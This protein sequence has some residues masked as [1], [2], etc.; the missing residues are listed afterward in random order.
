MGASGFENAGKGHSFN[1][2]NNVT[3]NTNEIRL[4]RIAA[5]DVSTNTNS[6]SSSTS[7]LGNACPSQGENSDTST[8]VSQEKSI[9]SL[10]TSFHDLMWDNTTTTSADQERWFHQGIHTKALQ[11]DSD[12]CKTF[13]TTTTATGNERSVDVPGLEKSHRGWGLTQSH[14]GP[15]G[16][17]AAIQAEMIRAL[18]NQQQQNHVDITLKEI[19]EALAESMAC[20]LAR[21]ALAP[22][23]GSDDFNSGVT[24]HVVLV[25]PSEK[26]R[27]EDE[28]RLSWD[29][30]M[31]KKGGR[32]GEDVLQCV[33]VGV[34]EEK[35]GEGIGKEK[36]SNE[37][38]VKKLTRA[39]SRY[40][41][42]SVIVD[43]AAT[44]MTASTDAV[45][46]SR[47][48]RRVLEYFYGQGGVLLFTMSLVA[49]RGV[50]RIHNDMDNPTSSHLTT[51][52][53][54]SG[55][56]MINLLLTGQA[57]SNVF[58]NTLT[59][60]GDS[61]KSDG[62]Q[63]D[64]IINNDTNASSSNNNV[65]C[66]GI[67]SQPSIGYLSQLESL[68]YC[69]V[70]GYYKSPKYPIW[71]IGSTSH[72]SVLFGED[73][74]LKESESDVL[75]ERCRRAFKS[76]EG[77]EE[78]GFIGVDAL[79]LVLE[80]LDLSLNSGN[81]VETLAASLEVSGA[82]II[83]WDDFWKAASRLLT[84]ASFESVLRAEHPINGSDNQT[85]LEDIIKNNVSSSI[86]QF[87]EKIVAIS[88][89]TPTEQ[90]LQSEEKEAQFGHGHT[91]LEQQQSDASYITSPSP[92]ENDEELAQRLA[93]EWGAENVQVW[94]NGER[95]GGANAAARKSD[96]ELARELQ[97]QW[98]AIDSESNGGGGGNTHVDTINNMTNS[99]HE[100]DDMEL[101]AINEQTT[102][103]SSCAEKIG[104]GR[105]NPQV[106]IGVS[107]NSN[108][109]T[110]L[111]SIV[112]QEEV[113]S[114]KQA[115]FDFEKFG[116]SFQLHHYNG[117]RGGLLTS[118]HVTRLSSQEAV[119]A[120]VA[121]SSTNAQSALTLSAGHTGSGGA[122]LEDIVRTKYP[123]CTFNWGG[124][125]P[126]FID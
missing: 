36:D 32:L 17:L 125:S 106:P 13:S 2:V 90:V 93:T 63:N 86:T 91:A 60:G 35:K 65:K 111:D 6:I 19:R 58:D 97:A 116:E 68:R 108:T 27:E 77:G 9:Q 85:D 42:A 73:D 94:S 118:F 95:K 14:G 34:N 44:T 115:S 121:L 84:G 62:K 11:L 112:V 21:A 74:C 38:R 16:I 10:L 101:C 12:D 22:C 89:G 48:R 64:S 1:N 99:K 26:K 79:A 78:N 31:Q 105:L 117:L 41:L 87:D 120:S 46:S 28:G 72:F 75:L 18:K 80:K 30:M 53:G 100:S 123:S 57:V 70:G 59:L 107:N 4:R 119:G 7:Q 33:R 81:S 3:T 110:T 71:V 69:E 82:G 43:G 61:N 83:L 23:V 92:M 54:M 76:V 45:V 50:K 102:F 24:D 39:I 55:Q 52:F 29:I 20:I 25:L 67:Q 15:C 40:L 88:S 51:Q 122:D 56:E 114:S 113:V 103:S 104:N 8:V 47:R 109:A 96:E 5:L 37:L 49:S 126:P 124:K 66:H 98:N